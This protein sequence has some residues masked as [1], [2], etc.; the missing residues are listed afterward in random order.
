MCSGPSALAG[1]GRVTVKDALATPWVWRAGGHAVALHW[2]SLLCPLL[3]SSLRVLILL[4]CVAKWGRLL[5]GVRGGDDSVTGPTV[6][7]CF[8]FLLLCLW[9]GPNELGKGRK[10]KKKQWKW[11][12]KE[13][14][15]WSRVLD[16]FVE[17]CCKES[18]DLS[19]GLFCSQLYQQTPR[20]HSYP[21]LTCGGT[22]DC[23]LLSQRGQPLHCFPLKVL[24][25][26]LPAKA[27]LSQLHF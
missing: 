7:L 3:R 18:R 10:K 11:K 8:F 5:F 4:R 14:M 26:S 21:R 20:A 24:P 2:G 12:P 13:G 17:N 15:R 23:F 16:S 25:R 1:F 9:I 6:A 19:S 22:P 27:V